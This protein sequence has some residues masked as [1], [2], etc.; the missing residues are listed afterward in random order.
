[1]LDLLRG[2]NKNEP[3][4]ALNKLGIILT[5]LKAINFAKKV[6]YLVEKL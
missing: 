3:L 5:T 1:V 6:G 2:V 4:V